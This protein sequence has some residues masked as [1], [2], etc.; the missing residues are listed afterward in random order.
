M[1]KITLFLFTCFLFSFAM[2]IW[3]RICN[4]TFNPMSQ[5]IISDDVVFV[6]KW[7]RLKRNL[8]ICNTK[9]FT[10]NFWLK[11]MRRNSLSWHKIEV[12]FDSLESI[13]KKN[14]CWKI[15]YSQFPPFIHR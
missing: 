4:Q 14:N 1:K 12:G 2:P 9:L 6:L 10:T 5:F 11:Y 8:C 13:V 15:S 7:H 3:T